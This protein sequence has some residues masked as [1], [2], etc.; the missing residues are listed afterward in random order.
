MLAERQGAGF[1]L[2][3][4][5]QIQSDCCCGAKNIRGGNR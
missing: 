3:Q 4:T 2:D 1:A 5:M